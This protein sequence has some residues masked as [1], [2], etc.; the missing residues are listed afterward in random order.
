M[1]N[2]IILATFVLLAS[3]AHGANQTN[4]DSSKTAFYSAF[5]ALKNMLEGKDSLNYEKAVFI[6]ENAYYDNKYNYENFKQL[7]DLNTNIVNVIIENTRQKNQETYKTLKLYEQKMFMLNTAN[8]GIFKYITDTVFYSSDKNYYI[9][10]YRYTNDDPYGSSYWQNTQVLNLLTNK[11]GNCYALASLFKIFS[12]R[13]KSEAR[14]TVTPHH[15]YI[16]NRNAKGDYKNVELATKTFPGDGSIQV[17]TYTTKTSIMNGMAQ[18][19]LSDRE[20][21]ALNL[22]Y[23]AKGFQHKFN[24][25]TNDFLLKCADLAFKS[26]T[27]SINALLLKAE[28]T[29]N[30]LSK[31]IKENKILTVAQVRINQKTKN[32]LSGYENQLNNLYK[33]GYREIPKDIQHIIISSIQ[34]N[35][36]GYITTDKTP[37]PFDKI[38]QKQRYATLSW[39]L[40][41]EM[42]E[43]VDT[44]QYFHA[45][46]N[47]KTK[48]IIEL[49]PPDTTN[50][51]KVDPVV[52]AM[53]VDPLAAVQ[54]G[55]TP[56]AFG[57]NMGPIAKDDDGRICIPCIILLAG[58]LTAPSVAVAPTGHSSDR[59]AI[60][61]A[62]SIQNKWLFGTVLA[63]TGTILAP[64]IANFVVG[65]AVNL[66]TNPSAQ[67]AAAGG[68]SFAANL[69]YEGPDDPL[70][71][72]DPF[73]EFGKALG[74][75]FRGPVDVPN[76]FKR[77]G[78]ETFNFIRGSISSG[79]TAVIG[80]GM[81]RVKSV[82]GNLAN[83][84]IFTPS[85]GALKEWN[86]I[87]GKYSGQQ[88][89]TNIVQGTQLFQENSAWI[90][91]V[92]KEG[93]NVLDLG[94]DKSGSSSTFYNME[95]QTIYN[96]TG[97]N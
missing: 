38:G 85:T 44:I 13:L 7:L 27:L 55:I 87:V 94:A 97:G 96:N 36:D 25:G 57:N 17:L 30:R 79:K 23:L 16:Q 73:G 92:K 40:F 63:G 74:N 12:D 69:L 91:K 86:E 90:N 80:Q 58:L 35:N 8:W 67:F 37:N 10:P 61:N 53:S 68:A 62:Y 20:A 9:T 24:D 31:A 15:I 29:E 47:T 78:V 39:G 75:L 14:L 82:A 48:K 21:I 83:A 56:Y 22:I 4:T 49:L 33:Y 89:P 70:P 18:R 28:V 54:P 81:D 45:S 46:L 41:D 72:P 77:A 93:Y 26:D 2:K 3:F 71:T 6:T 5:E 43:N 34:G 88:V 11:Q 52:F 64:K 19:P 66:A 76:V 50:Y 1:K 51:Y 65:Q 59:L 42:H 84:E 95:Q 60:Q 32:L